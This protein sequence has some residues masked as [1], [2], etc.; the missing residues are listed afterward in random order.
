MITPLKRVRG[1]GSAHEGPEHFVRQRITALA[2]VLLIPFAEQC[3]RHHA[4]TR[5]PED[6]FH[7]FP[8]QNTVFARS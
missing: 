4:G 5:K 8:L 3:G 2:N 1:L 7:R 6:R